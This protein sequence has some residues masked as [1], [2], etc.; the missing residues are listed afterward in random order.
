[1]TETGQWTV[2]IAT[3]HIGAGLISKKGVFNFSFYGNILN[4]SWRSPNG[5]RNGAGSISQKGK[6]E[7]FNKSIQMFQMVMLQ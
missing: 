1:M 5:E 4:I 2:L 3:Y 7:E 6:G